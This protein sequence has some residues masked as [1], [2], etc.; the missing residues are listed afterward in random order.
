MEVG[1]KGRGR[2]VRRAAEDGLLEE[3]RVLSA[4]LEAVEARRCRDLEDGDDSDAETI[5]TTDGSKEEGPEIRLL[6]YVLLANN[7][8]KPALSNYDD[9][10]STEMLLNWISKLDKYFECEEINDEK[11]IKFATTKLKGCA[12]LWWDSMQ[13]EQK[14]SNKPPIKK[15][16]RMV[17]KLKGKFLPKDY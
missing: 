16:D 5:V 17:A 11:R 1:R 6:K 7:N 13:A 8:R 10:L 4:R 9:S 14:R 12:T 3:I 2:G 15:W